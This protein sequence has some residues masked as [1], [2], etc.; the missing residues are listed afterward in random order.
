MIRVM[1]V[2]DH[3]LMMEGIAAVI[4]AQPDMEVVAQVTDGDRALENFRVHRP[5]VT[6]M[7]IRM[8][9][10]DGLDALSVIRHEF[11]GARI[12]ILTNSSGDIQAFRAFEAGAVGYLVKNLLRTGFLDTIR[13]VHWGSANPP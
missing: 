6:L 7:D 3:P 10:V 2:D 9:N 8:P 12:V 11:P 5:D 1:T 4:N 13:I